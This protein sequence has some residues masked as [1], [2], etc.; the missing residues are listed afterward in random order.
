M[1]GKTEKSSQP[2]CIQKVLISYSLPGGQLHGEEKPLWVETQM[3]PAETGAG[4][5]EGEDSGRLGKQM[6]ENAVRIKYKI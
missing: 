2:L 3:G 4:A 5:P 1:I 6:P